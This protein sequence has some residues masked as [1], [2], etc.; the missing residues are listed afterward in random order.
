MRQPTDSPERSTWDPSHDEPANETITP[1]H[2]LGDGGWKGGRDTSNG[3]QPHRDAMDCTTSAGKRRLE[4]VIV[5]MHHAIDPLCDEHFTDLAVPRSTTLDQFV[6]IARP[7]STGRRA[8]PWAKQGQAAAYDRMLA[9]ESTN[10][11]TGWFNAAGAQPTAGLTTAVTVQ[12]L[13]VPGTSAQRF[14]LIP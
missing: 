14:V 7:E 6:T 12:V 4:P 3:Y 8:A 1:G 13:D 2:S 5:G 10:G 9:N 11:R